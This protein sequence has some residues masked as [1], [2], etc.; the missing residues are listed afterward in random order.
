[1]DHH[2]NKEVE[3]RID[4]LQVLYE[5][6][7]AGQRLPVRFIC[8]W[9]NFHGEVNT[10][11]VVVCPCRTAGSVHVA[12]WSPDGEYFATVGKVQP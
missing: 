5:S 2:W 3:L 4:Q 11:D 8:M 12:K 1:M 6:V 10:A 9:S 7:T